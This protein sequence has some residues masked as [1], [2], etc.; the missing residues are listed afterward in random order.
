MQ[1]AF[2]LEIPETVEE[3]LRPDRCALLVYDMQEAIVPHVVGREAFVAQVLEAIGAAREAGMRVLFCRHASLPNEL[4]GVFALRTAMAW[5][6]AASV[7]DVRSLFRPGSPGY[8]LVPEVEPQASEAVFDK[9]AMSMFEGTP[10][11]LVLRDC[12]LRAFAICG[13]VLEIGIEPT[14]RQGCDLGFLPVV[15]TDACG[16]VD[17]E[18]GRR[19]LESLDYAGMSLQ[20]DVVAFARA[21]ANT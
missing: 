12:A 3:V 19:T 16:S 21:L 15:L 14:V 5:Q 13:A 6:G 20:T 4:S 11:E 1:R 10:L 2:G 18:A 7:E 9:L 17:E 8:A